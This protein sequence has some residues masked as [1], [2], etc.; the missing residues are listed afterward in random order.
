M[1]PAGDTPEQLADRLKL[2]PEEP[3]TIFP[4]VSLAEE[5]NQ[6]VTVSNLTESPD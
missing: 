4:I 2:L 5:T 6:E 1:T 3:V